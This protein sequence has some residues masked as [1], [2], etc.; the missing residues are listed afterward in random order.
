MSE[1]HWG[2]HSLSSTISSKSG[3]RLNHQQLSNL[4]TGVQ[5]FSVTSADLVYRS[6]PLS[7]T[8]HL[9]RISTESGKLNIFLIAGEAN[10]IDTRETQC[11]QSATSLCLK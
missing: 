4:S 1:M 9:I 11:I 3:A 5:Q 10:G 8:E 7:W 2:L 6:H